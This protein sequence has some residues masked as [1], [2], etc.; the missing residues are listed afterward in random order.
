MDGKLIREAP[1]LLWAF[2]AGAT[3]R[4]VTDHLTARV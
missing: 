3:A 1:P 4:I 2:R